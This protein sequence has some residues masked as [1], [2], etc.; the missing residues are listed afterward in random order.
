MPWPKPTDPISHVDPA[1]PAK[2]TIVALRVLIAVAALAFGIGLWQ[3]TAGRQVGNGNG[4]I[5]RTAAVTPRTKAPPKD[6]AEPGLMVSFFALGDAAHALD[7]RV[8]R[9][10]ALNVPQGSAV[11][12]MV[13]PGAFHA[14]IE[15]HINVRLRD[16]YTF[17]AA[18]SGK[19]KLMVNGELALEGNGEDFS[20]AAGK[21][22]QLNKGKNHFVLE[23]D[24]PTQGDA[25]YRIYWSTSEFPAEPVPPTVLTH[26]PNLVG[27]APALLARR[28]REL[29]GQLRCANCHTP[30]EALA[31]AI[32]RERSSPPTVEHFNSSPGLMPE[33]AM[34]APALDGIGTRVNEA[35]LAYWISKPRR[36]NPESQMPQ[37]L[38]EAQAAGDGL[39]VEAKALDIAAYLAT[40]TSGSAV[41]RRP[42]ST[43]ELVA[44]GGRLFAHL[45]CAA[46]HTLPELEFDTE[47]HRVPLAYV[48]AKYKPGALWG[49]LKDP[50]AHYAWERM[51]NFKLSD[52][53][54]DRL[55][56]FLLSREQKT[57]EIPAGSAKGDAARGEGLVA[58]SGCLN[59]HTLGKMGSS[60]KA[61]PLAKLSGE[62]S[63][64][65]CLAATPPGAAPDFH[66]ASEQ[67][68]ALTAFVSGDHSSLGRENL[69]E[70][71][72]RQVSALRCVN[73]H[74]RD[75]QDDLYT[76]VENEVQGL[77]Q[78]GV[79]DEPEGTED[80]KIAPDQT[81]PMLT[82][83]G[84]KLR[85]EWI[86]RLLSGKLDYRLRPWLRPRMPAFAA[87]A[88]YLAHGLPLQHGFGPAAA[89]DPAPDAALAAIGK[90]L[91]GKEGGFAC[92]SCHGVGSMKPVGVFEAPGINFKFTKERITHHYYT[93]WVYNPMRIHRESKMPTFADS[94]GQTSLKETLGGDA[95]KQ[96]EAI[97][98]YLR[99][100]RKIEPP[101]N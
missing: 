69:G 30:G 95:R 87:R 99:A 40:L 16:T 25:N 2:H 62:T 97:W 37:V 82:W 33:L 55:T 84:E 44:A 68:Q 10:P 90:K 12:A 27:L 61:A 14:T 26:N 20:S 78:D 79:E 53:E 58:S 41:S 8:D 85:P 91:V 18:G 63:Q 22:V 66:F 57:M 48:K 4:V 15:G 35:W 51:P 1:S 80:E 13:G 38:H 73:C 64:R 96:Y 34:D 93:R 49:F 32:A 101:E 56:A 71:A 45:R 74:T 46:C 88:V 11:S 36:L 17:T 31:G 23:Y 29:F 39:S 21:P 89:G 72:Q 94:T 7:S 100:G 19:L 3:R 42:E 24:S 43:E 5:L 70:F 92:I 77:V 83:T 81:I 54:A 76:Q 50:Q 67:R 9:L 52:L 60:L 98:N 28:G 59:C 75:N 86:A 47:T 65:G 6:P